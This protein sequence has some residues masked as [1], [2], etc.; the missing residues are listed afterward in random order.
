MLLAGWCVGCLCYYHLYNQQ[1]FDEDD[2]NIVLR[3]NAMHK[4]FNIRFIETAMI[5]SFNNRSDYWQL[6]TYGFSI[7]HLSSSSRT[8]SIKIT[9][10]SF[11]FLQ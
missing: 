3:W 11:Q 10:L 8:H 7:E 2:F 4:F 1:P 9:Q 6:E 5:Y